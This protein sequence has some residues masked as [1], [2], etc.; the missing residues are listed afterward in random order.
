MDHHKA[1]GKLRQRQDAIASAETRAGDRRAASFVC[2]EDLAQL[3]GA[4][5]S[6]TSRA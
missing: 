5:L 4:E 3:S 6:T 2:H 1:V